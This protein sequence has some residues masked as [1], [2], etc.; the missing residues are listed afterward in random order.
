MIDLDK[1]CD[2][3]LAAGRVV[4]QHP[5]SAG[6]YTYASNA[7]IIIRVT[8]RSTIM[9]NAKAPNGLT[10]EGGKK[11]I[12]HIMSLAPKKWYSVPEVQIQEMER[13]CDCLGDGE[14]DDLPCAE[15]NGTG[16]TKID[17]ISFSDVYLSWIAELPNAKIAPTGFTTPAR[18]KFDGGEGL[19]MPMR[20]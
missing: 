5:W 20:G 12:N 1:F 10:L 14:I 16:K 4:L 3:D 18:F 11:D 2:K 19:L 13:C 8:R 9:E 15:C 7:A 17:G 6:D